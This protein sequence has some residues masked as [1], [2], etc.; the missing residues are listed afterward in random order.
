[1]KLNVLS[2]DYKECSG[3]Q[4]LEP[5]ANVGAVTT[6]ESDANLCFAD[7]LKRAI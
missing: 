6:R 4:C 3:Y 1:M 2:R 5:A 7:T